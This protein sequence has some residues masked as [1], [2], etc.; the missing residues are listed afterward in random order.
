MTQTLEEKYDDL[1][2]LAGRMAGQLEQLGCLSSDDVVELERLTGME[3]E[4]QR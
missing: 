4:A 1:L 3:A 2:R